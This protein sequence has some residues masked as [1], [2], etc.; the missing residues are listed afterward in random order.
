[1]NAECLRQ[2][3]GK[4]RYKHPESA[5]H[6]SLDLLRLSGPLFIRTIGVSHRE[7]VFGY[8]AHVIVANF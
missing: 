2:N 8:F 7:A 6:I 4:V 5:A 3:H 1:M